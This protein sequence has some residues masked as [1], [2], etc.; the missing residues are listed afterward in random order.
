[1]KPNAQFPFSALLF[2][3]FLLALAAPAQNL[4][5]NNPGFEANAGYYTPGW[6]SWPLGSNDAVP[7]WIISLHPSGDGYAGAGTNQSPANLQGTHFGYLYS[8]S[9]ETGGAME[10]APGQRAPVEAGT[11]YTLWFSARGDANW[12]PSQAT[13]SLVW[14]PNNNNANI[15]G[16]PQTL[17]LTF[18]QRNSTDDLLLP[19]SIPAVAP[20]GAHYAS[21]RITTPEGTYEPVIFDDFMLLAEPAVVPISIKKN[22]DHA[23]LSW[24]RSA[25]RYLHE[26]SDVGRPY[27]WIP[28]EKPV[29]KSGVTNSVDYPF[30]NSARFFRVMLPD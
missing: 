15:T 19:Y 25:A 6:G 14:H 1:M 5:T 7:G 21:V 30:T 12:G 13:F 23:V 3:I 9:G 28:V 22:G 17:P 27:S 24:Q 8:G 2:A 16:T 20:N 26:S 29:H 10:T 18:P 4:L 11:A